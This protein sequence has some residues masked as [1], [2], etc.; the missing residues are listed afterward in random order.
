MHLH[1]FFLYS[2]GGHFTYRKLFDNI[3]ATSLGLRLEVVN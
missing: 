2:H 1:I 3:I